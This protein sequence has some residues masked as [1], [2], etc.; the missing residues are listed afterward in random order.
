MLDTTDGGDMKKAIDTGLPTHG[1]PF[2]WAVLANGMIYTAASPIRADGSVETGDIER[3]T[4]LTLTNL[5]HTL[6][7]AGGSL[8]DVVQV[9]LY[10]T[11]RDYID[12]ITEIWARRFPKPYPN[13]GTV[14]V[15]EIGVKG[16]G[17]LLMVQAV[18]SS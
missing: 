4:D 10:V 13:R 8:A 5:E 17:L 1:R 11:S 18:V 3:Q 2:E 12:P 14:I 9:M 6:A 7:A 16:V 15:S